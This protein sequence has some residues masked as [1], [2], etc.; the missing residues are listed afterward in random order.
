MANERLDFAGS[1]MA[2]FERAQ[3]ESGHSIW[4][5]LRLISTFDDA[6]LHV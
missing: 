2:A 6:E 4:V 3:R 1:E 5:G